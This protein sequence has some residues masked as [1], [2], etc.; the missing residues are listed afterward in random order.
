MLGVTT[1]V[2]GKQGDGYHD[3]G[4]LAFMYVSLAGVV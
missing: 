4:T 2:T 1:K 3:P